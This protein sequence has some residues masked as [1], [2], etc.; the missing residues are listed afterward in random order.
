MWD[1]MKIRD[2]IS[3]TGDVLVGGQGFDSGDGEAPEQFG[4]MIWMAL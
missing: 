2:Q 4:H 1:N 3:D